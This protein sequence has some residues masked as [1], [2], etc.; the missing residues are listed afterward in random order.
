MNGI[1]KP[2]RLINTHELTMLNQ[3]FAANLQQWN[4]QYALFA[5][6]CNLSIQPKPD[7]LPVQPIIINTLEQAVALLPNEDWS[8]IK[9]CLFGK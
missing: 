2:Y 1:I 3:R 4:E 5:L 9:H 6:G 7:C 8:V